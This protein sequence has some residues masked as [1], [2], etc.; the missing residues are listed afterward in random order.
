M[1][2]LVDEARSLLATLEPRVTPDVAERLRQARRRLDEPLRVAVAGRVKAGKSTL[3]NAVIGEAAAA[4]DAT[5]CTLAVTWYADGTAYRAWVV[6]RDGGRRQVPYRRSSTAAVV[7]LDGVDLT[8]VERVDVQFPSQHLRVMTLIDTPGIASVSEQVSARAVEFLNP[9]HGDQGAD[10]VVYLVRQVHERDADFLEAFTDPAVASVGAVRSIAVLS[11]ADEVGNGRGDAL[12]IARRIA[13]RY[14]SLPVLAGRVAGVLPV[15]GLLAFTAATLTE[16]EHRNL[17]QLIRLSQVELARLLVSVDGFLA[18]SDQVPL[19]VATRR[20]LLDRFGLFGIRLATSLIQS[21][22]GGSAETLAATLEL[23]SGIQPL[24]RTLLDRFAGRADIL[25]AARAVDLV[26]AVV[27]QGAV[28]DD[29]AIRRDLE[30]VAASSHELTELR[31]LSSAHGLTDDETSLDGATRRNA[32]AALGSDGDEPW[33][34]LRVAPDATVDE[35]VATALDRVDEFRLAVSGPFVDE[36]SA[37]IL[38]VALRSVEAV[39]FWLVT[40]PGSST[41]VTEGEQGGP[42]GQGGPAQ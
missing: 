36:R 2:G 14:A 9:D 27:A 8:A 26:H 19:P 32:L 29:R 10:V 42:V 12:E 1:N 30:R 16:A 31:C 35:L 15:A 25:K 20:A 17:R 6:G 33:Q 34:R 5:E 11:R 24:R 13:E 4:T 7:D 21:G 37:E 28:A 18:E 38:R 3:L 39:H 22:T 41:P 40:D 23:L